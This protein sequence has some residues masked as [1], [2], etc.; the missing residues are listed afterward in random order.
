[1]EEG[2][3][4]IFVIPTVPLKILAAWKHAG[5]KQYVSGT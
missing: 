3:K 5:I 1:M 4:K 2:N